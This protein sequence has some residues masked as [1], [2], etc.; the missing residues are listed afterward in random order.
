MKNILV[1]GAAVEDDRREARVAMLEDPT[2][3]SMIYTA[4]DGLF[5]VFRIEEIHAAK[6]RF[7]QPPEIISAH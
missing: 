6:M 5:V 1:T 2:G 3:P 7:G 4:D